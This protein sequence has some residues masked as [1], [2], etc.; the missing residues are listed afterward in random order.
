MVEFKLAEYNKYM[1]KY[2][3]KNHNIEKDELA[4]EYFY[5]FAEHDRWA[6][7]AQNI[8]EQHRLLAHHLPVEN[9][10]DAALNEN[11]VCKIVVTNN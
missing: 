6:N 7:W 2:S 5:P 11:K 3:V 10:E 1:L 4:P 9:S 8:C